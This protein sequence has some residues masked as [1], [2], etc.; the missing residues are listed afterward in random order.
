MT[1]TDLGLGRFGVFV[2][3]APRPAEAA[4][5][6]SLGYGT[7]WVAG[8]PPAQLDWVE[9]LLEAT[10][11]LRV[12]TAIVN[13]W[14]TDPARVAETF[15]RIET[16]HPGRFVLGIGAGHPE[17]DSTYHSPLSALN[18]YLDLLDRHDVPVHRRVIAA[19]GPKML[20]LSGTRANGAIPYL[21]TRRHTS[22]AR[23]ILGPGPLLAPEH[24]VLLNPNAD[25]ARAI[26]RGAIRTSI[27]K[28][29]YQASFKRL[30]FTDADIDNGGSDRLVD[31]VLTHGSADTVAAGLQA[32][33]AAGADHV[34]IQL[35]TQRDQLLSA[36]AEVAGALTPSSSRSA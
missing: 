34:A 33:F 19:L 24:K 1:R 32:L 22:M 29:N 5:I 9:P 15:H 20:D 2:V 16:A 3:G 36:L 30:G 14:S 25:Q 23:R 26:G 18:S 4:D 17:V 31:A 8:S 35:L 7:V 6:E 10:D 13:V 28:R 12:G 21:T 11:S 27:Q